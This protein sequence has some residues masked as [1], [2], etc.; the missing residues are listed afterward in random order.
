MSERECS[1]SATTGQAIIMVQLFATANWFVYI[2][3]QFCIICK[4]WPFG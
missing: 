2:I 1:C 3:M 4:I